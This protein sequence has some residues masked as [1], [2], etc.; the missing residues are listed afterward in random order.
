M[1]VHSVS[2][3]LGSVGSPLLIMFS[4]GSAAGPLTMD[5]DPLETGS[6]LQSEP[7]VLEPELQQESSDLKEECHEFVDS[8][9]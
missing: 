3:K 4:S 5:K 1:S 7:K 6:H 2:V 9:Y 8:K